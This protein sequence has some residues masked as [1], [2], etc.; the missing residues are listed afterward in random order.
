MP[1]DAI[2]SIVPAPGRKTSNWPESAAKD[3]PPAESRT[4]EPPLHCAP[5]SA[6]IPPARMSSALPHPPPAAG[7]SR[8]AVAAFAPWPGLWP[9]ALVLLAGLAVT[10][11][12]WRDAA[13]TGQ[14]IDE[15]RFEYRTERIRTALAN[16]L[17]EQETVLRSVAGLIGARG[18]FDQS[19]WRRYFEK[20]RIDEPRPGRLL[21]GFAPRVPA[22]LRPLHESTARGE[23][24]AGYAIRSSSADRTEFTPLAY[25]RYVSGRPVIALGEDLGGDPT[26]AEA[27]QR[28]ARGG[29]A[30]LAGP[31]GWSASTAE[32][33]QLWAVVVP[34]FG[35]SGVPDSDVQREHAA[36]GFAIEVF[37]PMDTGESVLGPDRGV[38][39]LRIGDAG[40]TLFSDREMT[41]EVQAG[42]RP[43]L[44]R[45]ASL[46]YGDH[47]W[48]LEFV[49]LSGYPASMG[50]EVDQA[51]LVVVSGVLVSLL[52]AGLVGT[53]ANLRLRA[54]RLAD[55][56]TAELR[57]ALARSEANESRMRAVV[58]HALD[59]I[60][61]ID[62]EGVIQTF[63]PAAERMFG[64]LESEVRGR[65][66]KL[67]MPSPDREQ[68]DEYLGRHLATGETRIIGVGREVRGLRKDGSEFPL[69]LGISAMRIG[70]A[71]Q[72]CGILRDV[73]ARHQAALAL[74]RERDLLE[75]RVDERTRSLSATNAALR[76]EVLERKRVEAELVAARE[77]ALQAVEAKAGFLAHMSHEIRTPMNAVIGMTALLEETSLNA[78]QRDC[79][80]TIRTSGDALLSVINDIL[81]FSK[82]ESGMLVLEQRPFDLEACIEEAVDMIAPDAAAKGLELFYSLGEDVPAWIAG[83]ASRLRQV[84][85]NL[86]SNAVKFTDR[87]EVC[88]TAT[89]LARDGPRLQVQ[90][91]VRDTG[92]GIASH[93]QR[94]LFEAFTQ[95]DSS[96]T[97][98]YGGTGLGLAICRRL[99]ELMGGT[100]GVESEEGRGSTFRFTIAAEAATSVRAAP[101]AGPLQ[102]DLSGKRALLVDDNPTNLRILATQC[103]R[104]KMDVSTAAT[105]AE[106][107]AILD[108]DRLYDVV[109]VDL[110]MPRMDGTSL[111]QQIRWLCPGTLPAL[112]LLSS[113]TARVSDAA[114]GS[115]FAATLAKPVKHS[116]LFET[117]ARVLKAGTGVAAPADTSR[118]LDPTTAQRMP[119]RILV[120][121]DSAINQKLA[122]GILA[123]L[124]YASD[125][126]GSGTEALRMVR[127]QRYDLVFMDLQMPEMDGL[128]ATR[129]IVAESPPGQRPRIVAMTANAL[130][131]DRERCLDAG[132]DDYIAK[133]VLPV[134][135]QALIERLYGG[136][137]PPPP[138]P[139]GGS[140]MVDERVIDELRQLEAPGQP[141][142]LHGLMRD[143]L[144][145]TPAA[146]GDLRRYAD[147]R[148]PAHVAQRA[149][150]LAGVSASL[151]ARGVGELCIDIERRVAAGDLTGLAPL[152][153]QLELRFSRTREELERLL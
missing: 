14:A 100:I 31:L 64:H 139:D 27:M 118:R 55:Q 81:D 140:P 135:V 115:P 85:V 138:L 39:G 96:T 92:I 125:V 6:R 150:R 133:P 106:A 83:D 77:Q 87:G 127:Q 145:Q 63:N 71:T 5:L 144:E 18:S 4:R 103:R 47:A 3:G 59:A 36:I 136:A 98:K 132:M 30:V 119:L 60:I 68:H 95:A 67:L 143:Y 128:E 104:W 91:S 2:R 25:V 61:T 28:A 114:S 44:L 33:D 88:L 134:D 76:Q 86:L 13:R 146:I 65:N 45:R 74:Q 50:S 53:L 9:A 21:I 72:F 152:I 126:A 94:Q 58:D 123:R 12:L 1:G 129:R 66:V 147:R 90:F 8:G 148:E 73:T 56:R 19:Q 78:E 54:L 51:R 141:S 24:L 120:A 48:D 69:E 41:R 107:L 149:H 7:S 37:N 62:E 110:H 29:H 142:L 113:G 82:A 26:A 57:E 34:V 89:L 17:Q 80:Q 23:G 40:R 122:V 153:D 43:S 121:E 109:V 46:A 70:E 124:G 112:V 32:K 38:I 16:R 97:R 108:G 75:V 20:V 84:F 105:A 15:A 35:G 99:V 22:E 137:P 49:A 131:G 101:K 93:Q 117:L 151:G 116:Q 11:V 42:F 52:L 130:A 79:V 111:A 102:V 10:I